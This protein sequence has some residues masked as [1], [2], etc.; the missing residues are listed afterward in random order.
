M[1]FAGGD[2]VL[3][4]AVVTRVVAGVDCCIESSTFFWLIFM[5]RYFEP[6]VGL[7]CWG[8]GKAG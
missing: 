6:K 3:V 8:D 5:A 2:V 7:D 4:I 1:I